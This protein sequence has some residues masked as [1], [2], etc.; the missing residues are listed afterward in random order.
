M[1]TSS[2]RARRVTAGATAAALLVGAGVLGAQGAVAAPG[3]AE[4]VVVTIAE[5]TP[6]ADSSVP[7]SSSGTWLPSSLTSPDGGPSIYTTSAGATATW[8]LP[9]EVDG[10]YTIQAGMPNGASS[11][12][13]T[14]YTVEV[15]GDSAQLDVNQAS[16]LGGWIDLDSRELA[17][18]ELV[19]VTLEAIAG[20]SGTNTR[21]A[22]AR[23]L[24]VGD[25]GLPEPVTLPYL[26]DFTDG[27][28]GWV[29]VSGSAEVW[30]AHDGDAPYIHVENLTSSSGSYLRPELP[31][32]LPESYVLNTS[33]RLTEVTTGGTVTLFTDLLSPYSAS[34]R[35]TATQ[36]TALGLKM[37]QPNS[38]VAV[39]T[40]DMP[41]AIGDWFQLQ[42]ARYDDIIAVRVNGDLVS[43]IDAAAAGGT[44]GIGAY[45]AA[46]DFGGIGIE[47]LTER[48]ADFPAEAGG[49]GWVPSE[50]ATSAQ[51]VI[52]NQTGYNL[53][54]PMRF[55]APLAEDGA[56]FQIVDADEQVLFEGTIAGGIGD[57]TGFTPATTG[58]FVIHVQGAAGE[59][60]SWDFGVGANWI[61]RVSYRNA[62]DFM[63]E[64]RCFYGELAGKPLNGTHSFCGK[65]L[66][67]RDSHQMSYE[68]PSLVDLYFANPSVIGS[69][70][71]PDAVYSGLQYPTAEG[72]PEVARLIAWAAEIYLRGNYNHTL[73]KEQLAT[74][75]WAYPEFSEWIPV[76]L[77]NDVRD[78]LFPLWTDPNKN[79]YPWA[80]FTEHTADLTQVYT[81]IGTGKGEFPVG[82]SI[83]PNLHLWQVAEREGRADANVYLNAG[84]A[85]AQWIV[86]NVDPAD[87]A[88]TKGQRQAEYHLMTA[89]ATLVELVPAEQQPDG[90]VEFASAW[91]DTAI[92]RSDN[93]WDFRRYDDE[94]WTIPPFE[95]FSG[96]L[97]DPNEPGNLLGF[98]AAALATVHLLGDD[99]R[100]ARLTEIAVA[101]VDNIFGRNPTGRAATYR[102]TREEGFE[103]LNLG[104][105][106][107]YQGGVGRLQGA[108]G[109]FDGG[110]KNGHYPF[111]PEIGNI[112]HTE[113]WVTFN[114]A[115]L[116][117]LAWRAFDATSVEVSAA[118]VPADGTV[119]VTLRAPLNMDAA[120]GNAGQVAVTVGD[121]AAVPVTVTQTGVNA[122]D[123]TAELDLASL[124]AVAGDTVTVSYGLG[125][126]E[127]SASL[128]VTAADDGEPGDGEPGDGEPGDGEPGDGEPGDGE[129]GDGDDDSTAPSTTPS[130]VD[131]ADA[132]PADELSDA[133]FRMENGTLIAELGAASAGEWFY[134]V[135]HS[136][137]VRLGWFQA[138]ATGRVTVPIPAGL[139]S[140]A[141]TLQLYDAS[142]A[143]IAW[144]GFSLAAGPGGSLGA[145]GVEGVFL[146]A[147]LAAL[148][149]A[150]GCAGLVHSRRRVERRLRE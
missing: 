55:T 122:L 117:G 61:E 120:G 14:R 112:G 70:T 25:D 48:P 12:N 95:S 127:R 146:M 107:E 102:A 84:V 148:A 34:A 89:L 110:P 29:P 103:G 123:Y 135:V 66:G 80:D 86:D 1:I 132:D 138:D 141:H 10:E 56:T 2:K 76:E 129:P 100:T 21:V 38:G 136:D 4:P 67:W 6:R 101:Q 96:V 22:S 3:D 23:L 45:K 9:V 52:S 130:I 111:H 51:P 105:F 124:G 40:G 143:L 46:A 69:I 142:G 64:V 92:E 94:R 133:N 17:A 37:A 81:Q 144:G 47:E 43:S 145:T 85:Q 15:N 11:G 137:P 79:R 44:F 65:G 118:S 16:F 32:E 149:L 36:F 20:G 42:V 27:L 19:T 126:F 119:E 71:Y 39:C 77:Y 98:P 74:F 139:P 62:V 58:P 83:V 106:S 13:H 88:V 7:F 104:W 97:D 134:A 72:S 53:G 50:G 116:R 35:H 59:G 28:A 121:A 93:M 91:A 113:G 82:H 147:G 115:W 87:P 54:G 125:S 26:E 8:T 150:L 49:C 41:A 31:L 30:S 73:L 78:Y 24:P 60:S 18:G 5:T 140:G 128:T 131:P 109:V 75:L 108:S 33:M 90:I 114:T 63:T 57:F 99:P 68:I